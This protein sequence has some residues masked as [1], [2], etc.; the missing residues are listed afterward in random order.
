MGEVVR[1]VE[2]SF[3]QHED[4]TITAIYSVPDP[5]PTDQILI[6]VELLENMVAQHNKSLER[7]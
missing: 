1:T 3:M 4:G 7:D 2:A 6:T 5:L